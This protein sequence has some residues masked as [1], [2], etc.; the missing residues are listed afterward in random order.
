MLA[1]F[2][3][4]GWLG[5]AAPLKA[6]ALGIEKLVVEPFHDDFLV[7]GGI[8]AIEGG[9]CRGRLLPLPRQVADQKQYRGAKRKPFHRP[10]FFIG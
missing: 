2:A 4:V 7:V 5:I 10:P 3:E 1:I 9:I 8:R 6:R